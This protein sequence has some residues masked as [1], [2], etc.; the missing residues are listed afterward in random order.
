MIQRVLNILNIQSNEYNISDLF[1][2][3]EEISK[4]DPNVYT[5]NF[6]WPPKSCFLC[7]PT[8]AINNLMVWLRGLY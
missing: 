8:N 6:E 3:P 5:A 7:L 4:Q 1:H 2:F